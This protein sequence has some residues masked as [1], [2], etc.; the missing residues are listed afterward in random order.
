MYKTYNFE[1]KSLSPQ[2][3]FNL[4]QVAEKLVP[5]LI[6]AATFVWLWK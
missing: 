1:P 6:I 4:S 2:K 5:F 3:K